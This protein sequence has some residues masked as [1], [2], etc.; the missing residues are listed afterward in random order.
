M[1]EKFEDN[2]GIIRSRKS[3]KGRQPKGQTMM[4]KV[5]HRKL[6]IKNN[7]TKNGRG[8]GGGFELSF[9]GRV[10]SSKKLLS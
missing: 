6:K 3:K 10:S 8:G 4:Y 1:K 5:L 2:K 9:S 7:T